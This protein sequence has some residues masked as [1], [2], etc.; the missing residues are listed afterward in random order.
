MPPKPD[1]ELKSF[2]MTANDPKQPVNRKG[3]IIMRR[4]TFVLGLTSSA[5]A[6]ALVALIYGI[7][8]HRSTV[9]PRREEARQAQQ[10][11]SIDAEVHDSTA[12]VEP[13]RLM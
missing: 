9:E 7:G 2:G 12:V 6:L 8:F 1:I 3:Q 13:P 5:V 11:S 10:T 4:A